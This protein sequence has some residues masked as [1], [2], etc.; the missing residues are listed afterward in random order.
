MYYIKRTCS[1]CSQSLSRMNKGWLVG[2][3]VP[4]D[5]T[6]SK[7]STSPETEWLD[8]LWFW[9][10]T[11]QLTGS[12]EENGVTSV[13]WPLPPPTLTC[14]FANGL[15]HKAFW[16]SWTIQ[17]ICSSLHMGPCH[18]EWTLIITVGSPAPPDPLLTHFL[19]VYNIDKPR[20]SSKA[21]CI[22][23]VPFF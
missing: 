13:A 9:R 3:P 10:I 5:S 8:F 7:L 19:F 17:G 16:A 20:C 11:A 1:I 18:K 23:T 22:H 12:P 21:W 15:T 6:C 2:L 14:L 4:P